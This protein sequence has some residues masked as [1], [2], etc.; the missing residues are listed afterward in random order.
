M[1]TLRFDASPR[2]EIEQ[3]EGEAPK[4]RDY[5]RVW[6]EPAPKGQEGQRQGCDHPELA[7]LSEDSVRGL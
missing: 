4:D 5:W 3:V 1:D 2:I 6:C 7:V